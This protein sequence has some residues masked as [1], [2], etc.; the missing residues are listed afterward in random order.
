MEANPTSAAPRPYLLYGPEDRLP[1]G[2]ALLVSLQQVAAMVVG[3]VTPALILSHALGFAPADTSYLVSMALIAAG[4]GTFLQTSKFGPVG[5]GLLSVAGTS[6]AFLQPLIDAGGAGGLPLMFGMSLACAPTLF[7]FVPFLTRLRRVFTPL[8]SGVV[9][10]LIGL[11]IIPEAMP[12]VTARVSPGAPVWA[13]AA[14]AAAVIAVVLLAQSVGGNRARLASILLGVLAGYVI[15]ALFGWLHVPSGGPVSSVTLPRILPH[16]LSF[17]WRF[18]LPFAFIYLASL[19]EALGDMTAT[20]QLSGLETEGPA[21]ARRIRGGVLSDAITCAVSGIIGSF[22]ST[23][24]AQNNGVIQIT[25]VSSRHVGKWMA[26][27][28]VGLGLFPGVARWVTAM[29]EPVLGGMA[30]LLFGLVSVAGL[31]LIALSGISHRDG[32]IVALSLGIGLGTASQHEWVG[33]LHP[34]L[35]TF[36]GSSVSAGGLTALLLNLVLPGRRGHPHAEA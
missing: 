31:R 5:S 20:S 12:G 21:Y 35:Q 13:G 27:I 17:Q 11:S 24:Y 7:L 3:V 9:V 18:V 33:T 19:L 29:P 4:L 25:G 16:G 6:F 28:L 30:I 15:C 22:P 32:L 14:V 10:L 2:P 36:L 26:L 8:V 1:F 34:L 23:T